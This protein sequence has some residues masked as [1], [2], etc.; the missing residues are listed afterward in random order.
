MRITLPTGGPPCGTAP[1]RLRVCES[2]GFTLIEVLIAGVAAVVVLG[3]TL[4]LLIS[5][6]NV[7]TRDSEWA[8][9][10][11]EDRA[12]LARMVRDIRQATTIEEEQKGAIV[13]LA[14]VGGT[15]WRIKYTCAVAQSGTPYSYTKC[16]RL[17]A[18]VGKALPANGPAVAKYLVNGSE[19][20]SYSPGGAPTSVTVRLEMPA[21]GNLK[22]VSSSRGYEHR[23]VLEDA[24][25]MRNRYLEG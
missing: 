6:L 25:F 15:Q 10:L 13:F 5:S 16:V 24:A 23:V 7:Q 22:Q 21:K 20:F 2:A 14:V 17:A 18:E 1:A 9:A 19:V 4:G 8:L 3:A 12:G 11:Q